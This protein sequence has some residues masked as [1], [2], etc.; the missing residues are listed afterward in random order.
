MF[1][2]ISAAH[3]SNSTPATVDP[4][5]EPVEDDHKDSSKQDTGGDLCEEDQ[6]VQ[7]KWKEC[8]NKFS[9]KDNL[10]EHINTTHI[11]HKK[12]CEDYPCYWRVSTSPPFLV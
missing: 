1:Q 3:P 8:A 5:A 12:G 7:S 9:D 11:E 2:D 4:L 10:V 6:V